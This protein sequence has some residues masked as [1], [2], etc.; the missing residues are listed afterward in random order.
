[1]GGGLA[2]VLALGRGFAASSVNYG[3]APR[4][5]YDASILTGSCPVVAS[6]GARDRSLRG[7]AGRLE[8]ALVAAG[9]AHD[10]KEYPGAGHGF[11]ND[12][13][14]A[15]DRLPVLFPVMGRFIAYGPHEPS[16]ADARRRIISFFDAH[17][18]PDGDPAP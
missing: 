13:R 8:R 16:A 10:V 9:V 2:L 12:H 4:S 1:M 5:A 3:S 14:G 17:L 6:Y 18:R 15:G 11:L 7:A